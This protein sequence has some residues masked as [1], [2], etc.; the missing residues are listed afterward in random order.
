MLSHYDSEDS[1]LIDSIRS[2]KSTFCIRANLCC[3]K[4]AKP[5]F[6]RNIRLIIASQR[7]GAILL[8][9]GQA[10][11]FSELSGAHPSRKNSKHAARDIL[12]E[13]KIAGR[14]SEWRFT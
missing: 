8:D 10:I 13:R 7:V 14:V 6:C 5:I 11:V 4:V 12:A 9:K 2:P 3:I 1:S